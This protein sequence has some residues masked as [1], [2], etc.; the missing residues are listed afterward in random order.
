[1]TEPNLFECNTRSF[2]PESFASGD[3]NFPFYVG[4]SDGWCPSKSYVRVGM[5]LLGSA[6]TQPTPAQMVALADNAVGNLFVNASLKA[7]EGE[8]SKCLIGLPQASALSARTR[9]SAWLKSVAQGACINEPKFSKRVMATSS[10]SPADGYLGAE[11]E[12][13]KPVAAASFSTATVAIS[14]LSVT[15]A[16]FVGGPASGVNRSCR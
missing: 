7:G 9:S 15:T 16:L 10:G 8:I 12:M 6:A 13:Y 11:N 1:M 4:P 5:T 2:A 14:P 3:L